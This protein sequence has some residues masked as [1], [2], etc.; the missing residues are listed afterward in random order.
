[1]F[2]LILIF[3]IAAQASGYQMSALLWEAVKDSCCLYSQTSSMPL[4]YIGDAWQLY[5]L[6][7]KGWNE[8]LN[9]ATS[10]ME[11]SCTFPRFVVVI[12]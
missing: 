4:F 2:L 6:A 12:I 9:F 10:K 5:Q 3:I 11:G 8:I 7:W 1:M